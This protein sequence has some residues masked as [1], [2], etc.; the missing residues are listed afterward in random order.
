M[1]LL[2]HLNIE[3][4]QLTNVL[5]LD[6]NLFSVISVYLVFACSAVIFNLDNLDFILGFKRF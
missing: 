6:G 1:F 3:P 5:N 2:I 4:G